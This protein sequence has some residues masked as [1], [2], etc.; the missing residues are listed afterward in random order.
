MAR[1]KQA[2]NFNPLAWMV[3][4][5]DLVT[6]LLTFFVMLLAMKAPEIKKLKEAF[7]VFAEGK[8][9]PMAVMEDL[10]AEKLKALLSS[11]PD[12]LVP[13]PGQG[14]P[15]SESD[16]KMGGSLEAGLLEALLKGLDFRREARGTV[17]TLANDLLF[18][19][20]SAELTPK[21]S[22]L[23][24]RVCTALMFSNQPL[25]VEGH[26]DNSPPTAQSPFAD[27]WQL[28][29]ARA[30]AV[31]REILRQGKIEPNRLRVGALGDSRPLAPN[32]TPQGRALNRRTEL[33][34]LTSE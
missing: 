7:G 13:E 14:L 27:N 34:I 26:A 9:G 10:R 25:L 3:T 20:G 19:P 16:L 22:Q 30:E 2:E 4:F 29:L 33:V 11:R 5:S 24:E 32:D 21:A 15:D 8:S 18:A 6:L 28:S 23:I 12:L 1:E 31:L 17:I